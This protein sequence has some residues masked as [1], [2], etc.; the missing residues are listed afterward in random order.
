MARLLAIGF[1]LVFTL[2]SAVA[3]LGLYIAV[4]EPEAFLRLAPG[5]LGALPAGLFAPPAMGLL[6]VA[7]MMQRRELGLLREMV[8]RTADSLALQQ[9]LALAVR[10]TRE[11]PGVLREQAH[12]GLE[13]VRVAKRQIQTV[14]Q[15]AE[16]TRAQ[17]LTAEW[18]LVVRELTGLMV[19]MFRLAF[20]YRHAG[21]A[22]DASAP[23]AEVELPGP[24][25]LPLRILR[26]L[27]ASARE[28]WTLEVDPRFARQGARYRELFGRFLERVPNGPGFADRSF[29]EASVY[30]QIHARLSLLPRVEPAEAELE[31]A[32]D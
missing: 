32:A 24:D 6:A 18:D 12:L 25:E 23:M 27:P 17:R 30:G 15:H 14:M 3:A 4:P 2:F 1:T 29:F 5:E 9:Q 11:Q 7:L 28:V 31:E 13:S 20:G 19:P 16:Q 22:G 21:A 26:M 10:E 8:A